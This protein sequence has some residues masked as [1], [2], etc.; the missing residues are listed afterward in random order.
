MVKAFKDAESAYLEQG[1]VQDAMEMYQELHKWDE[2]IAVAE[3]RAHPDVQ[4]L[5]RN[6]MQWLLQSNQEEKAGMKNLN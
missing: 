2:S 4:T 3:A 5:R 1:Q 6:Y